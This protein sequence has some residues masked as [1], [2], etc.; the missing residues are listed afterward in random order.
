MSAHTGCQYWGK[1]R[2]LVEACHFRSGWVQRQ[3]STAIYIS[4]TPAHAIILRKAMTE[5]PAPLKALHNSTF[6]YYFAARGGLFTCLTCVW[7]AENSK[8]TSTLNMENHLQRVTSWAV[9]SE[10]GTR[11]PQSLNVG[12]GRTSFYLY[13][14][15]IQHKI[16]TQRHTIK[17]GDYFH[18]GENFL[19]FLWI[20]PLYYEMQI[21]MY[22]YS[23]SKHRHFQPK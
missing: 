21:G 20:Y 17:L 3:Q 8:F 15:M 13:V 1:S 19:Q 23:L 22:I 9:I 7:L 14:V 6:T 18:R 2:Y 16:M 4:V 10:W 12:R 5:H 11:S